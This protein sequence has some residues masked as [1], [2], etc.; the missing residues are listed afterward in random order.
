MQSLRIALITLVILSIGTTLL[1]SLVAGSAEWVGF[2]I[3]ILSG[4]KARVILNRYL[5]LAASR[6]WRRGFGAF[7]AMFLTGIMG[8]YLLPGIL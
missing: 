1:A 8:L 2:L 5:G 3:L 7:I 4:W 6:V